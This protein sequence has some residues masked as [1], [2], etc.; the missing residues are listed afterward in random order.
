[1]DDSQRSGYLLL[2]FGIYVHLGLELHSWLRSMMLAY[3]SVR[4]CPWH[5]SAGYQ[6]AVMHQLFLSLAKNQ[7]FWK[8]LLLSTHIYT[9]YSLRVRTDSIR[10]IQKVCICPER[11]CLF[12]H[13]NLW[14]SISRSSLGISYS[15][16][17]LN[18]P[19]SQSICCY[20]FLYIFFIP[21]Q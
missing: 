13:I 16:L 3:V 10:W 1:M 8:N 14:Q 12:P 6:V 21:Y 18:M 15:A 7:C 20:L 2:Q 5:V 17:Q 9:F 4:I 19:V 11:V